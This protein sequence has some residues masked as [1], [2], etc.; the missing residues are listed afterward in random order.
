MMTR[1]FQLWLVLGV[2]LIV[3]L[4]AIIFVVVA[5]DGDGVRDLSG[6]IT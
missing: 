3:N 1:I 5:G 6:A 4:V 2:T